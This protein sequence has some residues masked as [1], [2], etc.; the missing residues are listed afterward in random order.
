MVAKIETHIPHKQEINTSQNNENMQ[1][2]KVMSK[3]E[4]FY[5]NIL[6]SLLFLQ[7]HFLHFN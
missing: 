6:C 5:R 1:L 3:T 4:C 2:L 7:V